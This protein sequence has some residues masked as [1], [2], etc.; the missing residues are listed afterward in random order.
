[1]QI[2]KMIMRAIST[3]LVYKCTIFSHT[4]AETVRRG[5]ASPRCGGVLVFAGRPAVHWPA[6]EHSG[7][8]VEVVE[9]RQATLESAE[10][11]SL[12]RTGLLLSFVPSGTVATRGPSFLPSG[13]VAT[14]RAS[15]V[16]SGTAATRGPSFVPSGTTAGGPSF[17]PAGP[18]LDGTSAQRGQPARRLLVAPCK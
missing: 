7:S 10:R 4:C 16:P 12:C 15:F 2:K 3:N 8:P 5:A 1:M 14:R 13:T 17:V 18:P 6:G 11:R 9:V